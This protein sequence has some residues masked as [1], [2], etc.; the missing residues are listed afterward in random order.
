MTAFVAALLEKR[1]P[2]EKAEAL[3][4][5]LTTG[6][7]TH[8]F[9]ITVELASSFGL[10]IKTDIPETVYNLMDL[11]PQ[12]GIGRPSVDYVPIRKQD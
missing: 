10:P 5:L 7:F 9:P 3:A 8:D 12:A 2:Q 11:Y 1:L 6:Q 4:A